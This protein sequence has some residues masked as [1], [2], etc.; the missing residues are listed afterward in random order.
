MIADLPPVIVQKLNV[1]AAARAFNAGARHGRTFERAYSGGRVGSA[2]V[3]AA[4]ARRLARQHGHAARIGTFYGSRTTEAGIRAPSRFREGL[5][6]SRGVSNRLVLRAAFARKVPVPL[7]M[8][9][10][11][12]AGAARNRLTRVRDPSVRGGSYLRRAPA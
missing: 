3:A 2:F 10:G 7:S 5:R 1:L 11:F 6:N 4:R 8:R 12:L 9:A